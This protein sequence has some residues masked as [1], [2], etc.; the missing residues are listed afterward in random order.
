MIIL[1][2]YLNDDFE[3]MVNV[4]YK[5]RIHFIGFRLACHIAEGRRLAEKKSNINALL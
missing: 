4:Q 1:V 3:T 5:Y 2:Q